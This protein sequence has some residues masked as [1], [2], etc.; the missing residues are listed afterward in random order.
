MKSG[1]K[2]AP[3]LIEYL[4]YWMLPMAHIYHKYITHY[5]SIK[6][7]KTVCNRVLEVRKYWLE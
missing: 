5:N 7:L 2:E 4:F 3:P 6:I 1:L